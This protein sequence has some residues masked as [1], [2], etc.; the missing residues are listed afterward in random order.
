MSAYSRNRKLYRR[1]SRREFLWLACAATAG[2]AASMTLG[3][4]ATDPVTGQ[5][6][7]MLMSEQEEMAVDRQHAIH[8][9]SS[10]YGLLRDPGL[11]RYLSEIG[12]GIAAVSHRPHLPYS[13][14]VVNANHVNAYTFPGGTMACTRGI[15]VEI[16]SEAALAALLGHET[17]HVNARH[18]ARRQTQGV[19][20]SMVLG[21]AVFAASESERLSGYRDHIYAIGA[22]GA[23]ALLASYSR[24]NEREADALGLEYL[25]K[26][27]HNPGGMLDLMAM[28]RSMSNRQPNALELMFSTHP[29]SEERFQ[30]AQ[31]ETAARYS[32]ARGRRT[33][34]ERYMDNTA[35]LRQ[36]KPAIKGM[37]GGEMEMARKNHDRAERHF[38][39]ALRQ[40]P[41]DYCGLVLM[42]KCQLARNRPAEAEPYLAKA[43]QVYPGEGQAL[44]VN[45][46]ALLTLD[47]PEAALAEFEAYDRNL[48]GNPNIIFMTGFACEKMQDRQQASRHYQRYL[49]VAGNTEQA[50]YARQ[51]LQEWQ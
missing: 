33:H 44:H 3:G 1:M 14:Q 2:T 13:F 30:T 19:L 24:E 25:E 27:G 34:H 28:L 9:F 46:V 23:G 26:A 50:R 15:M 4:C 51:R 47:R 7:L 22:V 17:G 20:T 32:N 5:Q 18:T 11:N 10:D 45:G 39:E 37:Q 40:A 29:M 31:Q 48:P 8:Q 35:A 42:A 43:K 21:G 41:D 16:E 6:R 49:Q 12:R 38:A 36:L